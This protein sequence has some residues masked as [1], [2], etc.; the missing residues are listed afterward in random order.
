MLLDLAPLADRAPAESLGFAA[1]LGGRRTVLEPG[2]RLWPEEALPGQVLLI[3]R[4]LLTLHWNDRDGDGAQ[5]DAA[6]AGAAIGLLEALARRPCAFEVR[7]ALATTGLLAPVEALWRRI[8]KDPVAAALVWDLAL[9]RLTQSRRAVGCALR[10]GARRRLADHL[11]LLHRAADGD[12]LSVTQEGLGAALGVYRTTVT[13]LL[14]ELVAE[15]L[16]EA[17]RGRVAVRD[18][19]KLAQAA[20]GCRTMAGVAK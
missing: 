7:A 5:V 19:E 12:R 14:A 11:L 1:S 2:Q 16:I 10:H 18:A 4:G 15:G 8:D 13:A 6:G 20:C 17:G 3:E 9:D